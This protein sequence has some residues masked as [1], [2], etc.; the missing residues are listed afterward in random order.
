MGYGIDVFVSGDRG[1]THVEP[2]RCEVS[3][4]A[5][6]HSKP[7]SFSRGDGINF[8]YGL[9][10]I[11]PNDVEQFRNFVSGVLERDGLD[12]ERVKRAAAAA[13]TGFEAAPGASERSEDGVL[14][15]IISVHRP[16]FEID[17]DVVK[18]E[19][20]ANLTDTESSLM[21]RLV[22]DNATRINE[23]IPAIGRIDLPGD[24]NYP[25]AGTGWV[26][27]SELGSDIVVTNAHV[28]ELFAQAS[29]GGFGFKNLPFLE[30]LV[31]GIRAE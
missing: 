18:A 14:E 15:A 4:K 6:I 5:S 22:K 7:A 2:D 17:N 21:A 30:R 9:A 1:A 11:M 8:H 13:A 19:L 12:L 25:W 3:P 27:D 24:E 28:A 10:P 29:G 23:T 31:P 16:V 26:V 20:A